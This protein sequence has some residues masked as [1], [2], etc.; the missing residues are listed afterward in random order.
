MNIGQMLMTSQTLLRVPQQ[1]SRPQGAGWGLLPILPG[2]TEEQQGSS[3]DPLAPVLC[4][5]S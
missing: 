4:P 5:V 1:D 3:G 2:A